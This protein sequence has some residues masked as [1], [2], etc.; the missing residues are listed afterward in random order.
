MYSKK[1][2]S[3]LLLITSLFLKNSDA[4]A[5]NFF[6]DDYSP[7]QAPYGSYTT[8]RFIPPTDYMQMIHGKNL[9]STIDGRGVKIVVIDDSG[10]NHSQTVCNIIGDNST[11]MAPNCQ[12]I[13][14]DLSYSDLVTSEG[15]AF[16]IRKAIKEK[17]DFIN[18]SLSFETDPWTFYDSKNP[19]SK[20]M[21]KREIPVSNEIYAACLEARDNGICIIKSAGNKG[22]PL[23]QDLT[24]P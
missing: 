17:V 16:D 18:I 8:P 22:K 9:R 10:G 5:V 4:L 1:F 3:I 23:D 6:V 24:T 12:L 11:S 20:L 14:Q 7:G 15:I 21:R 13:S 19:T 2:I